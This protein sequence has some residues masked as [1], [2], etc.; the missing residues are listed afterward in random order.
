MTTPPANIDPAARQR[1]REQLLSQPERTL[2]VWR[3][4]RWYGGFW[5]KAILTLGLWVILIWQQNYITLTTRRV[6]QR[7]GSILNVNE[8]SLSIENVTDVTVNR[9]VFGSIFGY[10]DINVQTSGSSG[11]EIAMVAVPDPER[12]RNL[13]FDLTDGRLDEVMNAK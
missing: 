10:G 13:I 4:S 12:L 5:L 1:A 3:T 7:R 2:G 11:A 8:T 9:G 6:T